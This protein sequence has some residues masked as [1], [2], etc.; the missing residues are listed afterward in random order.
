MLTK[1]FNGVDKDYYDSLPYGQKRE[2]LSQYGL[3]LRVTSGSTGIPVEVLKS[4]D[5]IKRDYVVF[6]LYEEKADNI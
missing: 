2:Y 5:D 3:E 4:K 1:K 6:K